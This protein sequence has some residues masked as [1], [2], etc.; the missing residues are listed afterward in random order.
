MEGPDVVAMDD[1]HL[2]DLISQR[3]AVRR[4]L[5]GWTATEILDWLSARG[6]LTQLPISSERPC[7]HFQT[8]AGFTATFFFNNTEI[9]FVGDNTTFK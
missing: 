6:T 2:I 9:V 5:R 7:F 1:F 8:P 4:H 3:N